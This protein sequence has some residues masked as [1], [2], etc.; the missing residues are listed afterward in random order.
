M[1]LIQS[2][3]NDLVTDRVIKWMHYYGI[4]DIIRIN[5][6]TKISIEKI[7]SPAAELRFVR[8]RG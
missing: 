1:V 3:Q 7:T 2:E 5:E 8:Q 6:D 4:N